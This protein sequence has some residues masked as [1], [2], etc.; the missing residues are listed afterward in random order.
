MVMMVVPFG[1]SR[2]TDCHHLFACTAN[3]WKNQN[4]STNKIL[5]FIA[6]FG[7]FKA[8]LLALD[9]VPKVGLAA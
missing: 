1:F 2:L 8:A 3:F 5:L 7:I 9:P 4:N 6:I